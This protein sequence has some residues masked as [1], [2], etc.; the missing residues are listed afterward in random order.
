MAASH[1][2]VAIELW[3]GDRKGLIH[4]PSS[5][6]GWDGLAF[7]PQMVSD[8]SYLLRSFCLVEARFAE[9]FTGIHW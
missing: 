4:H 3:Y 9:V 8:K 5:F 6:R 2:S 1:S 7:G